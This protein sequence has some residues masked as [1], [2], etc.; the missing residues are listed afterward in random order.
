MGVCLR[1]RF[2]KF[3][4]GVFYNAMIVYC[5]VVLV[6][7]FLILSIRFVNEISKEINFMK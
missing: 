6:I 2:A 7:G 5:Y 1:V 3:F 4:N